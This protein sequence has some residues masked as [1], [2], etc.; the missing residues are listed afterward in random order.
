MGRQARATC[1]EFRTARLPQTA[2]PVPKAA[3]VQIKGY[4]EKKKGEP[5]GPTGEDY[6][7]TLVESIQPEWGAHSKETRVVEAGAANEFDIDIKVKTR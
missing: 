3:Q 6:D 5:G 7:P 1:V 4:M 2:P